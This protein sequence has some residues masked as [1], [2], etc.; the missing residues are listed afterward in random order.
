MHSPISYLV[1]QNLTSSFVAPCILDLKMGLEQ[2][3]DSL[4]EEKRESQKAKCLNSAS[5]KCGFRVGGVLLQSS[6]SSLT[7]KLT[8][9]SSSSQ[10]HSL[11]RNKYWGR[12]LTGGETAQCVHAFLQCGA[13]FLCRVCAALAGRLCRLAQSVEAMQAKGQR[14]SLGGTSLLLIYE[15]VQSNN[16]NNTNINIDSNNNNNT[17][18]NTNNNNNNTLNNNVHV[19][20]RLIDFASASHT[21]VLFFACFLIRAAQSLYFYFSL[22]YFHLYLYSFIIFII[23]LL[24]LLL[25]LLFILFPLYTQCIS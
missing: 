4:D 17:N 3:T 21:C 11:F 6:S 10:N 15:A 16:K 2:Y 5:S 12:T 13:V 23:L 19:D 22:S 8:S 18:T 1:I 20:V 7:T 9:S 24:L 25:L 14:V